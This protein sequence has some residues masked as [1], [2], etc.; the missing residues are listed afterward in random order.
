[1]DVTT[2]IVAVIGSGLLNTLLNYF[3]TQREKKKE[4]ESGV[5]EAARLIMKDRLRFLCVH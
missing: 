5:Q 3:I 4:S 2:I 1:M